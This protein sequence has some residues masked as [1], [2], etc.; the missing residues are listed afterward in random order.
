LIVY[1]D[2][3]SNDG[4]VAAASAMGA[5]VVVLEASQPFT[6][7]R[8]RNIGW[9]RAIETQPALQSIQFV[10]GDCEVAPG[11]LD[12]ALAELR[13]HAQVA[14]VCGQRRERHPERSPYN[15]LCDLE[16]RKTPGPVRECG[17]DVLMRVAALREVGGYR[18]DMIAGEEPELCVRLRAAGWRIHALADTMT[19]HDAA[20]TRF[21]Q[22]WNRIRRSGYAFAQGAFLH[23][24][25]PERHNVRES[26]RAWVW[27]L[28]LPLA[29]AVAVLTWEPVAA[30]A[31]LAYPLQV[32]RLYSKGEGTPHDRALQALFQTLGRFPEALGQLQFMRDRTLGLRSRLI[33]YK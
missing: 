15:R 4:S 1:V 24:A 28:G 32:I 10:D 26:R 29:I 19:W 31:L 6:A 13:T 8:A 27:G 7:A 14:A 17:G 18:D 5:D 3:G 16:W 9:R 21:G 22:W 20:L 23:G 33:E 2:S 11:W 25:P 30:W 12:S